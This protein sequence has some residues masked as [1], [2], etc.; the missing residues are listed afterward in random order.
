VLLD[1]QEIRGVLALYC[2]AVDRLDPTLLADV[3]HSDATDDHGSNDPDISATRFRSTILTH[4][5]ESFTSTQ[6]VLGGI[7]VEVA[8]D[9]ANSE[10]YVTAY[11][12]CPLDSFGETF[13]NVIGARYVDRFERRTG[14]WRISRRVAVRDWSERRLL[15]AGVTAGAIGR[16]DHKDPVYLAR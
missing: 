4:L 15:H 3:Y 5:R 12:V 6:H 8:G 16:R 9:V 13:M 10:T 1:Q 14:A 7:H 2:R 11:H